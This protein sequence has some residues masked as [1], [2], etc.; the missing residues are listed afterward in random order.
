MLIFVVF[1]GQTSKNVHEVRKVSFKTTLCVYACFVGLY[2][3][4]MEEIH[5]RA[6]K[7]AYDH[8]WVENVRENIPKDQPR[9]L[10][11]GPML[12]AKTAQESPT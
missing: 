11:E 12:V 1:G 8:V 4:V 3:F 10:E 7:L 6:D 2:Q 9:D 5:V